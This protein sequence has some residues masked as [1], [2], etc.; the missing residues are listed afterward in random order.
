MNRK[1]RIML[2]RIALSAIM[3]ASLSFI[4]V[5][6]VLRFILYMAAYLIIGYDILL[7]AIR[8]I[9]NGQVFDECFLMA[10]ATV[11]AVAL[12]LYER[13]GDY[14]EAVAFL[15]GG[16]ALPELCCREKQ[17]EHHRADGHTS[18]LCEHREGWE[19]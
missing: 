1:Q 13:S 6:G 11:G 7:K 16:R 14:T 9:I 18:R 3:V 8:G 5:S 2:M 17:E 15:S 19:A 10:I 12:A 4:P